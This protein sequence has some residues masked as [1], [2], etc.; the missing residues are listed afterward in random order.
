MTKQDLVTLNVTAVTDVEKEKNKAK[1]K[2]IVAERAEKSMLNDENILGTTIAV[3]TTKHNEKVTTK[4]QY[5]K[6][7]G[8]TLAK[9]GRTVVEDREM[10][11]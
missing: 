7:N 11:E 1:L 3:G 4:E 2:A 10:G 8:I 5:M 6:D 9:D